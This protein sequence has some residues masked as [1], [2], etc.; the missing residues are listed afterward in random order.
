MNRE[1]TREQT[2]EVGFDP[3]FGNIPPIYLTQLVASWWYWD[4]PGVDRDA[5]LDHMIKAA[6]ASATNQVEAHLYFGLVPLILIAVGIAIPRWRERF[7]DGTAL[8]W[9]SVGSVAV[10]YTTGWLVPLTRYLPGFSLFRGPARF[11]IVATFAAAVLAGRALTVVC[12]SLSRSR[13]SLIEAIVWSVTVVDLLAV[14]RVVTYATAERETAFSRIERSP[15]RE[16]L[17][18]AAQPVRLLAPWPNTAN[19]LGVSSLPI[20]LGFGPREYSSDP[21]FKSPPPAVPNAEFMDWAVR[22]GITHVLAVSELPSG[23]REP[24]LRE[25]FRGVDPFLHLALSR[26]NDV[27]L[28]LYELTRASGRCVLE[29]PDAGTVHISAYRANRVELKADVSRATTVVLRDLFASGWSVSVDGQRAD[30]KRIDHLFRGVDVAAGHH[31]VVWTF[32]AW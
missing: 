7:V 9:L 32:R 24:R 6:H 18:Q 10:I 31:V 25:V 20:Y 22:S 12:A 19:L 28:F 16:L 21:R 30:P 15:I 27:P 17:Q 1:G 23:E 14:G 29:D 26:P 11:G 4:R 3:G 13:R 5:A 2:T 8:M